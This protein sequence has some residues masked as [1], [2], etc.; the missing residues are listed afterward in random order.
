MRKIDNY[1]KGAEN[2]NDILKVLLFMTNGQW[3]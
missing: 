3:D 1:L 2:T